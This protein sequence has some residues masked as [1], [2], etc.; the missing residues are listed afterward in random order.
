MTSLTVG[1]ADPELEKRLSDELDAINAAAVGAGAESPFSIRL[2]TAGGELAGGLTGWTWDGCGGI[3]SLW[4]AEPLR[5]QGWGARLMAAAEREIAHRGGDRALVSTMSFQA[6]GFYRRLGYDE[7]GRVPEMP[8]GSE[9]HQFLKRLSGRSRLRLVA[10]VENCTPAVRAY[11]DDVLALLPRH[12]GR[13]ES[14]L[15]SVDGRTEVQTISFAD[16][17]GYQACLADPQR[18]AYRAALG[19]EAPDARVVLVA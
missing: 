13:L 12:G 11:E 10:I 4:V 3:T 5:G 2:T 15:V 19:D 6:P 7:V 14:R 9:K 8:G 16:E 17:A 1:G 18:A